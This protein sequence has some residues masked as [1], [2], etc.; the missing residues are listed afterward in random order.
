MWPKVH[1]VGN[2]WRATVREEVEAILA[3]IRD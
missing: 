1:E 3:A 2:K